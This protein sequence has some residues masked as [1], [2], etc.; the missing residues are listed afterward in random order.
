MQYINVV[1]HA[2]GNAHLLNRQNN[3]TTMLLGDFG[4]K[5]AEDIDGI[6]DDPSSHWPIALFIASAIMSVAQIQM[7]PIS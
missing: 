6:L 7:H 4:L 3:I 1:S 5:S 2:H